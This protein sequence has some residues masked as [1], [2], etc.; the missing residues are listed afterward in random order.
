MNKDKSLL[1]QVSPDRILYSNCW[2]DAD[3]LLEALDPGEDDVILSVGSAGDNSF[4]LLACQP[5]SVIIYDIS[6]PQLH[7]INLKKT[8]F[9]VLDYDQLV[10]FL[11]YQEMED[12]TS[13]YRDLLAPQLSKNDRTFWEGQ[14]SQIKKGLI[15]SGRFERYFQLYRKFIQPC[16]T[17]RKEL[18]QFFEG[19]PSEQQLIHYKKKLDSIAFRILLKSFLSK[20]VMSLFG[21]TPDFFREVNENVSGFLLDRFSNFVLDPMSFKNLYAGFMAS[22]NFDIGL[23]HYIR[24]DNFETIR[25]NLNRME[26]RFG[27]LSEGLNLQEGVT[28]VNA[29]NIFEYMPINQF[30]DFGLQMYKQNPELRRI[31]YWNFM[32]DRVFA[33][34]LPAAFKSMDLFLPKDRVCFYKRFVIETTNR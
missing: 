6:R 28:L 17:S 13:I 2:E 25:K 26:I 21:R 7:L 4:S 34:E 1:P 9:A 16:L 10:G 5:K 14:Q 15:F 12:R 18:E 19:P 32:V 8:A 23:P 31:A 27:P 20:P 30:R 11:G 33:E 3:L 24:K 29:S 22:G